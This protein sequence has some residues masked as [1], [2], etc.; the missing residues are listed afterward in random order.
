[1]GSL[2]PWS[3]TVSVI[4]P[5]YEIEIKSGGGKCRGEN[6]AEVRKQEVAFVSVVRGGRHG[7][8][9]EL[10]GRTSLLVS[11]SAQVKDHLSRPL[12]PTAPG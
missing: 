6:K 3:V 5:K 7:V 8:A 11:P 10:R 12:S 1:M 2:P 9:L 4:N